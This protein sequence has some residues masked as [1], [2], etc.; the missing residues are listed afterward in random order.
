MKRAEFK[1]SISFLS[2]NLLVFV[3]SSF[4]Q[5]NV[6]F[7]QSSLGTIEGVL[8]H[9]A[10][11]ESIPS[12][13]VYLSNTTL[14]SPSKPDGS[15]RITKIPA[16]NYDLII[17]FVGFKPK[18]IPVS[19]D[20]GEQINLGKIE[21]Q[22]EAFILQELEVTSDR[23]RQWRRELR[24]FEKAFLGSSFNS[25][26]TSIENP[27]VLS[28]N[29]DE[30]SGRLIAE[31]SRDLHVINESLGYEIF[32]T[33][34]NFTWKTDLD[35]GS[36]VFIS[37]FNEMEPED[38]IQKRVWRSNREATYE[39]SFQHFLADMQRGFTHS[40]FEVL[41]GTINEIVRDPDE[42]ILF[43]TTEDTKY[44]AYRMIPEGDENPLVVRFNGVV[45]TE[46]Y[47]RD[48]NLIVLDRFGNVVNPE[49][50]IMAGYWFDYRIA[51]L[52]PLNYQ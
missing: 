19:I 9:Q 12:A 32:I 49:N 17:Q 51:D 27:E 24:R 28:F 34:L 50:I 18:R 14:G 15:F 33:L 31:A 23:P 44:T 38:Q 22:Q 3:L 41:N 35:I 36:Y 39:G 6:I 37:R 42:A 16:G 20:Q 2:A 46:L 26:K 48:N 21:L 25:K 13:N 45:S 5:F 47:G 43:N 10:T 1:T 40:K 8:I 7:A 52:L 4:I 30:E 29:R 11:N